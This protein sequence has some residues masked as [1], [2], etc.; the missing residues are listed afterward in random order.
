MHKYE[1]R[2]D[3][4]TP[5]FSHP[6]RVAM[7]VAHLFGCDDDDAIAAAFLHDTME[8][9]DEGYDDL[10]EHFGAD[11]ADMVVAL[12]KNMMLPSAE[13]EKEYLKRLKKADW[14]VRLI[15]LADEYDNYTDTLTGLKEGTGQ[16]MRKSKEIIALAK[17][18]GRTDPESA[19]AI[20]LLQKLLKKRRLR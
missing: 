6:A 1:C 11:V 19:R 17:S 4:E 16:E 18:D 8:D 20:G 7:T 9:T 14:R 10:E 5:Y 3:D 2:D 15:K 13:R 12:T